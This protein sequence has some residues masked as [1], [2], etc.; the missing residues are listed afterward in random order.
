MQV[1]NITRYISSKYNDDGVKLFRKFTDTSKKLAKDKLDIK[2]LVHCKVYNVMPKFLRFKLYRKSLRTTNIYK[3]FQTKL[4]LQEIANKKRSVSSLRTKLATLDT[5]LSSSFSTLDAAIVRRHVRLRTNEFEATTARTHADKLGS[6]GVNNEVK[7]CNPD[8]V[9]F[10]Y[11]SVT[12]S[13]RMKTLLAF[14]L[15][16]NLPVYKINYYQYFLKFERLLLSLK[17]ANCTNIT[18]FK[19][20]LKSLANKYYYGFKSHKIFSAISKHDISLLR[21]LACNKDII[22][23][24]PDKGN[25]VVILDR[26]QY[27]TSM[28][29]IISDSSKFQIISD[30]ITKYTLKIEDKIN[31]FIRKLKTCSDIPA[32]VLS[33]LYASGSSPGILYGLPKIHKSDFTTKFQHRP[34]FAAY[35]TPNFNLAKFLVPT[36]KPFTTN[37]YTVDNSINFSSQLN[38]FSNTDSLCMASFDIE[39]LYTNIPLSETIDICLAQLYKDNA[40]AAIY[41][42]TRD[43]FKTLLELSVK[44]CFFMFDGKFYRQL[45]GLG[46]GLPLGPTFANIFLCFHESL[47]LSNCPDQFKPVFY[48]RYIDD[49]FLLFRHSSHIQLFLDYL[50]SQ[51]PNIKFTCEI[52]NNRT[53][54]FLDCNIHRKQNSFDIS[55]FRKST[56]TGLGMS[57]FSF[58][59]SRFKIN[60]IKT[61]LS[62]A[63]SIC[64]SFSLLHHEIDFLRKYFNENGFPSCLFFTHV[65][66]FLDS[67]YKINPDTPVEKSPTLYCSMPFF[68]YPS[69]KMSRDL[70]NLCSKYFPNLSVKIILTNSFRISSLFRFKD[71]LPI[72]LRSSLVYKYCCP[73]CGS[74]YIG[75][76]SRNFYMRT[77]EHRGVSHRTGRHLATPPHSSIRLHSE[78]TCPGP[79]D[80]SDFTI[81]SSASNVH[82]LRILES[83][84]IHKHK[85][86]LNIATSSYPLEIVS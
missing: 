73:R 4:L 59:T 15:D 13:E 41:G 64:S 82:D 67:K 27:I 62:R 86:S 60:C 44:H 66:R 79:V 2:F 77:A 68:G 12:L 47:W 65:R 39:N 7:P 80:L 69:E 58:C 35:N 84:Y 33:K 46:M 5:S 74:A 40:T 30:D 54:S 53:L 22:V 38:Q 1:R 18:E 28:N 72:A 50:N 81:V 56:F 34:I 11:S 14:G 36:L 43:N 19:L 76:T 48:K 49:T 6:L 29:N 20:Q 25:G 24:K 17:N 16:F 9:V 26:T 37:D 70:S 85:P 63:Y 8:K 21:S 78:T 71:S 31:S 10:N 3:S 32:D 52:E 75:L 83:L 55:V 51:H 23:N 61:L 42:L 45:D 57:F